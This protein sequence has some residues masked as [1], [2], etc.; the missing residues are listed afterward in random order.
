[1]LRKYCLLAIIF[2]GCATSSE[3]PDHS[4]F[5]VEG[6][7]P[8]VAP[9]VRVFESCF[10][11]ASDLKHAEIDILYRRY[12]TSL[13]RKGGNS[14]YDHGVWS[15]NQYKALC[16]NSIVNSC[17]LKRLILKDVGEMDDVNNFI[18]AFL[19]NE[20]EDNF[21]DLS[22]EEDFLLAYKNAVDVLKCE[23]SELDC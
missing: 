23:R 4:W 21:V 22:S 7:P 13:Q 14:P 6:H 19:L 11:D 15:S 9:K 2:S 5:F 10:S 16:I 1:M 18:S 20:N 8:C 12:K 17:A 3:K